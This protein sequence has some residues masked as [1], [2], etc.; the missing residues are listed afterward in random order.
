MINVG[1]VDDHAIVRTSLTQFLSD[2]VDIRVVGVA[3]NGLEAID[4]VRSKKID[5]L[6]LDISMPIHS[7]IDV[8]S[9]L[10]DENPEIG[11]LILSGY[12]V[13]HYAV[14]VFKQGAKGYLG[15]ECDPC[16]IMEAIRVI[17]LGNRYITPQIS[18]L[19][20]HHSNKKETNTKHELLSEREFQI[21]LKLSS[22]QAPT[23]I[24][25]QLGISV[26]TI[27]TYRTRLLEKM[28]LTSNSDLTYY[29]MKNGLIN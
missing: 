9:D 16:E 7:G 15:K 21:F 25:K 13:E 18:N 10:Q 29:A 5:V 8:M 1:I 14:N 27:S 4:L 3:S 23:F 20:A 17:S 2:G 24:A 26:K 22:G 12:P 11:I 28:N 6:V 19:L